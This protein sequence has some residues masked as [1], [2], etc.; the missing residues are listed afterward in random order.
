MKLKILIVKADYYWTI[1]SGLQAA[2]EVTLGM[3]SIS[4]VKYKIIDVPGVFEIPVVIAKN[5][6]KYDCFLFIFQQMCFVFN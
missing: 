5:I 4:K 6:K 1:A 2:A 3:E